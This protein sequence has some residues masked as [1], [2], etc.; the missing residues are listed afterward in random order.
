MSKDKRVA[1]ILV[2]LDPQARD[3][4]SMRRAVLSAKQV[5]NDFPPP[6]GC[7]ASYSG[8]PALR[9]EI[10]DELIANQV[11]LLPLALQRESLHAVVLPQQ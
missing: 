8:L 11:Q 2:C 3:I 5:V 4:D 7:Q 10:V 1:A 6:E 9:V